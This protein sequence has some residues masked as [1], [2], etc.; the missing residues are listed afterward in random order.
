MAKRSKRNNDYIAFRWRI[1]QLPKPVPKKQLLMTLIQA[2]E[3]GSGKIPVGWEIIWEW[4]NRE[5]GPWLSD[6]FSNA[7]AK[8]RAGF[9]A[10]MGQRLRRD[11]RALFNEEAPEVAV[12][13]ATER[14]IEEL[15]TE[16][17][18]RE[19][20]HRKRSRRKHKSRAGKR[21]KKRNR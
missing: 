4:Q 16:S 20:T 19:D 10:L 2:A 6:T 13:E 21:G 18:E 14:E 12:R 5:D 7:I 17:E 1:E 9:L 11:Y 3:T 15:E 8:S